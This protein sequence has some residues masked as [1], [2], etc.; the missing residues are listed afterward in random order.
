MDRYNEFRPEPAC[1][2]HSVQVGVGI[3]GHVVVE[4]D[5]DALNVHPSAKQVGGHQDPPLE[6]LE[7]LVPG[8]PGGGMG[9]PID[10]E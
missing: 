10:L 4:D 7:L 6:V 3:L 1:K 8:K 5:V 9:A 2:A